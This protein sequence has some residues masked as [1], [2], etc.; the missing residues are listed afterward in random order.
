MAHPGSFDINPNRVRVAAELE[1]NHAALENAAA[2]FVQCLEESVEA[3][4]FSLRVVCHALYVATMKRFPTKPHAGLAIVSRY[5]VTHLLCPA[6]VM[7]NMSGLSDTY[8]RKEGHSGLVQIAKILQTAA[9]G[10]TFDASENLARCNPLVRTLTV[11][12]EAVMTQLAMPVLGTPEEQRAR[13][14]FCNVAVP[15]DRVL[16]CVGSLHLYLHR[17]NMRITEF[18]AS[19]DSHR[20]QVKAQIAA[21]NELKIILTDLDVEMSRIAPTSSHGSPLAPSSSGGI[22]NSSAS[23]RFSSMEISDVLTGALKRDSSTLGSAAPSSTTF[24]A[25]L[26]APPETSFTTQKE[27]FLNEYLCGEDVRPPLVAVT[28][29]LERLKTIFTDHPLLVSASEGL[30][31]FRTQRAPVSS[32]IM[33]L[34][35]VQQR[36]AMASQAF[37]QLQPVSQRNSLQPPVSV[38]YHGSMHDLNVIDGGSRN[39]AGSMSSLAGEAALARAMEMSSV[40]L[41]NGF[42]GLNDDANTAN[43]AAAE[44]SLSVPLIGSPNRLLRR[45]SSSSSTSSS[46]SSHPSP[47]VVGEVTSKLGAINLQAVAESID[48]QELLLNLAELKA[49]NLGLL[50]TPQEQLC[51]WLNLHHL[52]VLHAHVVNGLPSNTNQRK[53]MTRVYK[54]IVAGMPF[55]LEDIFD[56]I[57]RGN[58]KGT[59]KKDDPRFTHVLTKYDPRVHFAISYLTVSTSPMLIFHPESLALEL[60]VISKVFVQQSFSLSVPRKRVM[61]SS[62]FDTYLK[63]FGNHANDAVRWVVSNIP[64]ADATQLSS[65]LIG[66]KYDLVYTH[67]SWEPRTRVLFVDVPSLQQIDLHQVYISTSLGT[68]AIK[69]HLARFNPPAASTEPKPSNASMASLASSAP[70]MRQA[71]LNDDIGVLN[72]DITWT[73]EGRKATVVVESLLRQLIEL[74]NFFAFEWAC[75]AGSPEFKAF[76]YDCAELQKVWLRSLSR[77]ELTAFWLNV[78]NLLALHLC[79]MHRPF[80]HMSA[81]NVKQVSTSYKYCISGLDFSLRDISRTVLTR[82]FKLTDPRLELTLAAD[83]RVHFGLTM[84]ARGMPRLR[85]YDAA[86]LSEMLDVAARDVVNMLVVVDEAKLRLTAPEW[87]KRAYKDYFKSRQSGESEFANW[88]CSFLPESVA[89]RLQEQRVAQKRK[90]IKVTF[91]EFDWSPEPCQLQDQEISSSGQPLASL[92]Q[93]RS[94]VSVPKS[95]IPGSPRESGDLAAAITALNVVPGRSPETSPNLKRRGIPGLPPSQPTSYS[96]AP[97]ALSSQSAIYNTP[98]PTVLIQAPPSPSSIPGTSV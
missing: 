4:P 29:F 85:I 77:P 73:K 47:S 43:N 31:A 44:H 9:R 37:E 14:D 76:L 58:P 95:V 51:F 69:R 82:S 10:A 11:R 7:P 70:V 20:A 87:L 5:L 68:E 13:L 52:L 34:S 81:L 55:S 26:H 38:D 39:L 49:I 6:I 90:A 96:N 61:V 93:S 86:T 79:V 46:S 75:I 33:D 1:A 98:P 65:I 36:I 64:R 56:G 62:V 23:S 89:N 50:V 94:L 35:H 91:V 72:Q 97:A 21:L 12:L 2:L 80:V 16:A 92:L 63:D 42:K 3:C 17:Q 59:I 25:A 83:E 48:F 8:P 28:E 41:S 88:L 60:S 30:H 66:G 74:C 24:S 27:V 40:D 19:C 32:S 54:Y 84:Y 15:D 57:L 71:N 22:A 18:L 78:H 67:L 53:R 45:G